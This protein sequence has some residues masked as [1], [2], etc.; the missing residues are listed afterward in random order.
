MPQDD[1]D[2]AEVLDS[3]MVDWKI[4]RVY[5][6]IPDHWNVLYPKYIFSGDIN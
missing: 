2:Y 3:W 6:V 4:D 1:Y 5:T